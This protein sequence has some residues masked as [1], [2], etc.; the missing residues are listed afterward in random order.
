MARAERES[1]E[2]DEAKWVVLTYPS[3]SEGGGEIAVGFPI[4]DLAEVL[5]QPVP[6]Q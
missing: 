4:G 2:T 6:E 1:F 5:P 3:K